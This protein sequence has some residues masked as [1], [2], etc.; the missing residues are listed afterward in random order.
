MVNDAN[1]QFIREKVCQ[2]RNA[3]MYVGSEGLVKLGN[4]IVTALRVD[5]EGQLW[6]L[7]NHPPSYSAEECE[8]DFPA[9]LLFYKKGVDYFVEV[10]GKATIVNINYKDSAG[11]FNVQKNNKILVKMA[12]MNI[13]YT[14]PH[15]RKPRSKFEMVLENWYNWFLRTVSFSHEQDSV[16]KRLR[17]TN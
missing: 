16:L 8:Q 15:T 3:V 5:E 6:F 7:T 4:D 2:L 10:S 1:L 17:Q 11:K 14:E 12:M 13:E 9:R